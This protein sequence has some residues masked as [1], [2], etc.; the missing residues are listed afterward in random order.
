MDRVE[1]LEHKID[2]L[3]ETID[4]FG[5]MSI[6]NKM[7]EMYKV[8]GDNMNTLQKTKAAIEKMTKNFHAPPPPPVHV[9]EKVEKELKALRASEALLNDSIGE[10]EKII[11]NLLCD[12]QKHIE[13][14]D[15]LHSDKQKLLSTTQRLEGIEEQK[16]LAENKLEKK[17]AEERR[18]NEVITRIETER[19]ERFFELQNKCT[20]LQSLADSKQENLNNLKLSFDRLETAVTRISTERKEHT[21]QRKTEKPANTEEEENGTPSTSPKV[22]LYHDSLC[23][24]V[25]NTM[26][27]REKVAMEKVWAPTLSDTRTQIEKLTYS[28][29]CVVVQAL[30]REV[31]KR[32]PLQYVEEIAATVDTCLT[33]SE[34]VVLSL[35]VDR[36]DSPLARNRLK[37][38]NGLLQLKFMDHPK[39]TVCEHDSLRDSRN[40]VP[41]K[42]HLSEM[43]TAK[44]ASNL[45]HS[46]ADAIGVSVV[47]KRN[48]N[49]NNRRVNNKR[50]STYNNSRY[51]DRR[52]NRQQQ[53]ER[54]DMYNEFDDEI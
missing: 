15:Q 19:R 34:K 25:N 41:D 8:F 1:Q 6:T 13:K 38:V 36:E 28:P 9:A 18:L 17:K 52:N 40:R 21:R 14:I 49:F 16:I 46:I 35:I 29:A 24:H 37:A 31:E 42:L 5:L 3:S 51:N 54:Y 45:K 44:L 32:D 11:Q 12:K 2:S 30:T 48:N 22:V 27:A 10:K 50:N 47:K 26:M 20:S 23:K 43:G 4:K 7:Q 39:V 33:K 53:D